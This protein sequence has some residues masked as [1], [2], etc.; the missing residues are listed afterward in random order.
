MPAPT[1]VKRRSHG[2]RKTGQT[3]AVEK[4][5]HPQEAEGKIFSSI[6]ITHYCR[7]GCSKLKYLQVSFFADDT[8]LFTENTFLSETWDRGQLQ[9][10]GICKRAVMNYSN[11]VL[12]FFVK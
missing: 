10:Y 8:N 11:N 2:G 1:G 3:P 7:G 12:V 5:D 4:L 6:K 9:C